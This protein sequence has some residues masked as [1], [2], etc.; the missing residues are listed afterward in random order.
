L[1][2]LAVGLDGTVLSVALPTLSKALH[3]SELDLQWFTSIYLLVLAASMLP[4]GLLGDRYGKKKVLLISLAFFGLGSAA[5]GYSTSVPEFMATRVLMGIAGAGIIVMAISALTVLFA[6]EERP[7]AVGV[8]SAANFISLPVG[9]ILGGWLLT[10]YWWGWVFLI[11]VPVAVIGLAAGAALIPESRSLERPSVDVVGV[12]SSAAGL[13]ALM[14]GLIEAGQHGWSNV[15]ALLFIFVG[16]VILIGFFDWERRLTRRPGGEPLLDLGLFSSRSFTWGVILAAFVILSMFGVLFTMPQFF[17][18]VLGT[19]PIGSGLRLLPLMAGLVVGAIPAA[20]LASALGAKVT[21]TLGFVLLAAGL[22]IGSTTSA[23]S[24]GV[25]IMIWMAILGLGVGI[26]VAT[27]S[28]AALV[29]LTEERS[30]VGSAVLQAVNKTGAPLGAAIL[31]SVL[32]GEY[33]SHLSL[34][35][36]P[37]SAATAV[38]QSVFGGVVVAQQLHSSALLAS[39]RAAFASGM[40]RAL[41]VSGGIALIGAVLS[42]L[43]L[44]QTNVSLEAKSADTKEEEESVGC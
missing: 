13:V 2:V 35:G 43:F 39:V 31:G 32:S 37:A 16:L 33:L 17:Q 14:Y 12:T 36:L 25:F 44:P 40:D 42:A 38:R 29:E 22:F 23:H 20:K 21:T 27:T 11:N 18:G 8:W 24:S 3:A 1:A 4:V 6:K 10:H 41:L 30:G 34:S 26:A 15:E 28:S 5:S 9:P 19:N 7:K